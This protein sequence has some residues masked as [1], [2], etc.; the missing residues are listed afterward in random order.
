[1]LRPV[2]TKRGLLA[3]IVGCGLVSGLQG[4]TLPDTSQRGFGSEQIMRVRDSTLG[5]RSFFVDT[6]AIYL[7][8]AIPGLIAPSGSSQPYDR[9]LLNLNTGLELPIAVGVMSAVLLPAKQ[10][11][12]RTLVMAHFA[13]DADI[14]P[15]LALPSLPPATLTFLDEVNDTSLDIANVMI[16][17]IPLLGASLG[18]TRSDAI[19]VGRPAKDGTAGKYT[20]WAGQPEAIAPLPDSV[21]RVVGRDH[22]GFVALTAPTGDTQS[23]TRFPFDGS[24][25]LELVPSL[26]GAH[27]TVT[28]D[29]GSTP[30]AGPAKLSPTNAQ[31]AIYCPDVAGTLPPPACLLFYNRV[32]ADGSNGG[33][34]RFLD[35]TREAQLPGSLGE[36][37]LDVL[38]LAPGGADSFWTTALSPLQRRMYT[39][40]VGAE[41]AA[42]CVVPVDGGTSDLGVTAWAPNAG[43]FASVAQS[44][45][46]TA[47]SPGQWRLIEGTAGTECHLVATGTNLIRQ[48][49]FSPAGDRLAMLE[50]APGGASTLYV[51]DPDG[52]APQVSLAGAYFFNIE[53]HDER[54]L[55]LWHSNTDGY[56]LSWLD[57]STIPATEHPIA[58]RV[59]WDTRGSWAWLSPTW[60]LLADADLEQDGSYSLNVVNIDTGEVRL[61]SRGVVDFRASWATPPA[62]A[63]ELV[64]A[65]TVRGRTASSQDG[66]WAAHIP[67]ADFLP[68][69]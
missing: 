29:D 17:Y 45:S 55:L 66:I 16:Q 57:L 38:Q 33:F 41:H 59:R 8:R 46:Q 24:A 68:A 15:D 44:S 6:D 22:L 47:A 12:G 53:F 26:L 60:V 3:V 36:Q 23:L 51:A 7:A 49:L 2:L 67:L 34:M 62:D 40:H 65:Y 43:R 31:P 20:P 48:A 4:C 42:S 5:L 21:R 54:H 52:G 18:A 61:V 13:S 9:S 10:G 14:P 37:L 63:T 32:F 39:W 35:D 56:T 28:A 19:L 50:V 1:M 27:I 11:D 69:P 30:N 58:D 25:P 64:V